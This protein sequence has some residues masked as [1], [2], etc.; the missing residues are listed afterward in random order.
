MTSEGIYRA[1]L[2]VDYQ[3]AH[4]VECRFISPQQSADEVCAVAQVDAEDETAFSNYRSDLEFL[5][6]IG[7]PPTEW[8]TKHR[9]KRLHAAET[10][11]RIGLPQPIAGELA[12]LRKQ[13]GNDTL[14]L[15]FST[16]SRK[17]DSFPWELLGSR[18]FGHQAGSNLVVWRY[19]KQ[20]SHRPWPHN[21]V[22]LA[23]ASPPEQRISPNVN[24]E[25]KDI[26]KRLKRSARQD[27]KVTRM[28]HSTNLRFTA[29]LVSDRPNVLH[30][31]M[32]GD[33]TSIYFEREDPREQD[34]F[35]G[36]ATS[37]LLSRQ[38]VVPYRHL[39]TEIA[40]IGSVLTAVLSVC[41][42]AYGDEAETSFAHKLITEGVPAVIGM[43]GNITP[44]ASREFCRELYRGICNGK[45]IA[46]S[47]AKAIIN[48]RCI[49]SYDECLWSVPM[50]YGL[51]NVIPLP[52]NDYK[53]F[54]SDVG[55]AVKSIEDLR[56]N[57]AR[58]S[59]Q[60]GSHSGNWQVN[61]TR[62]AMG[63]GKVQKTL[64]YVRDNAAA[65][66]V[67]SYVWRLQF[68]T[69]YKEVER[70]ISLVRTSM[71]SLGE[72]AGPA[73]FSRGSERFQTVSQHLIQELDN[74][75][76]LVLGEFPVVS[77][78]AVAG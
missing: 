50:L 21:R 4:Q 17:L 54:L 35:D 1:G 12:L 76:S 26:R 69:S 52:T 58:L 33:R 62:A 51:D 72:A 56:R 60:V 31:A 2:S 47:Y 6:E 11:A 20:D 13:I 48:L 45:P 8:L 34:V 53:R 43:A 73:A 27:V 46:D 65:T 66:R 10:L 55:Q 57:L 68:D 24:G 59:L 5:T 61:S 19:V 29:A 18:E 32:H 75:R 71:A 64:K 15:E 40:D 67:D 14:L 28:R 70:K 38:R 22:M 36:K 9:E 42:S 7:P 77:D 25:F 49:P 74:I 44:V 23:A 16:N 63:L 3:G 39:A 78:A 41:F 37:Q 30:V